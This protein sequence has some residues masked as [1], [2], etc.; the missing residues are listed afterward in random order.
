MKLLNN[1]KLNIIITVDFNI[2]IQENTLFKFVPKGYR[3][4]SP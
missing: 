1:W 3:R 2:L 4:N